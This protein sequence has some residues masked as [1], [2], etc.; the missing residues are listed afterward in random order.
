MLYEPQMETARARSWWTAAKAWSAPG[1]GTRREAAPAVTIKSMR[2]KQPRRGDSPRLL[3]LHENLFQGLFR[4]K[5]AG[6]VSGRAKERTVRCAE[7]QKTRLFCMYCTIT[8]EQTVCG[9][10]CP[11]RRYSRHAAAGE[12]TRRREGVRH[13]DFARRGRRPKYQAENGEVTAFEHISFTV[14]KGVHEHRGA[15]RLRK[16]HAAFHH[17]RGGCR[18]LPGGSMWTER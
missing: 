18:P 5:T 4:Q 8:A 17:C 12:P 10:R 16:K 7:Y 14:Q 3:L 11:A 2:T 13:G 6:P 15:V 1:L 9:A